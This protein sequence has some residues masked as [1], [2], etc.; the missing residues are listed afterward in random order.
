MYLWMQY[1]PTPYT[2][3]E[4]VNKLPPGC[5]LEGNM[6]KLKKKENLVPAAYWNAYQSVM[7]QGHHK[8]KIWKQF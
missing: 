1:V 3:V 8:V 7:K 2:I 4:G 6:E 5:H